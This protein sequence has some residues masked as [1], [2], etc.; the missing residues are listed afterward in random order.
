M[1]KRKA[2]QERGPTQAAASSSSHN[3]PVADISST[4]GH[5]EDQKHASRK[6]KDAPDNAKK[7]RIYDPRR[8]DW[9][10]IFGWLSREP[11]VKE[12]RRGHPGV[13]WT[14][15]RT[16]FL[17]RLVIKTNIHFDDIPAAFADDDGNNKPSYAHRS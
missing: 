13:L 6:A 5:H 11:P 16:R 1:P 17:I 9:R 2:Q 12:P 4:P 3:I 10:P 14:E 15:E 7:P 8:H